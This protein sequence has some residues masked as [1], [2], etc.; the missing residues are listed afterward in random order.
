MPGCA[1]CWLTPLS[2]LLQNSIFLCYTIWVVMLVTPFDII[3]AGFLHI[4]C[5]SAASKYAKEVTTM[6]LSVVGYFQAIHILGVAMST[7]ALGSI[8]TKCQFN[9]ITQHCC[10]CCWVSF[11]RWNACAMWQG[12]RWANDA[13]SKLYAATTSACSL[14]PLHASS[15]K[16]P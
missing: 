3:A 6:A 13:V 8:L 15:S 1:A 9:S 14:A 11:S 2:L 10:M 12:C 4:G 5:Y 16:L 7:A